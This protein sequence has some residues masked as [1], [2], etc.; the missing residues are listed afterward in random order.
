MDEYAGKMWFIHMKRATPEP[1]YIGEIVVGWGSDAEAKAMLLAAGCDYMLAKDLNDGV[2]AHSD[3]VYLGYKR[4][5][6]PMQAIRNIISVHNEEY[7]S[8]EKNGAT[9]YKV[10]GNLNSYTNIF[11]DDIYLFYTK[12]KKGGTPIT[13]LGTS[14]SVANW[15]H[16]EGNRYVVKTVLNQHGKASDLNDGTLGSYIYLLQTRDKTD[17]NALASMIGE[18]SVLI[19]ITFAAVS[20]CVVEW[21]YIV[22]KKRQYK[23]KQGAGTQSN[24]EE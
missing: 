8:F 22:K 15:S 18:G 6:D 4:T 19:I 5:S 3:Y 7:T 20:A 24:S 14:G 23:E 2:G 13:S 11:A 16:G 1:K 21:I 10:N 17:Q 9:Y 12:D